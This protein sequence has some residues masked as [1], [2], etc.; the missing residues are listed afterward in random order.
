MVQKILSYPLTQ[1][2]NELLSQ[3]IIK[4][5]EKCDIKNIFD[6]RND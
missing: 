5:E 4:N 6:A 3:N 2:I 1:Q